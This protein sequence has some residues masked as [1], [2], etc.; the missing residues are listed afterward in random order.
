MHQLAGHRRV[1]VAAKTN[2]RLHGAKLPLSARI[3]ITLAI[4][5]LTRL[6]P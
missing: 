2:T 1:G 5:A 3:A 4:G 6:P